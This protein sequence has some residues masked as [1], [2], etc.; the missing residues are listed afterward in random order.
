MAAFFHLRRH[1]GKSSGL[2][3]LVRG[4]DR[5]SGMAALYDDSGYGGV[6]RKLRTDF[7]R[8]RSHRITDPPPPKWSTVSYG[9]ALKEDPQCRGRVTSRKRS[10]PSCARL[11]F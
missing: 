4:T 11:M 6:T 9:F 2:Y 7:F 5:R 8:S 1:G 10:S 3:P